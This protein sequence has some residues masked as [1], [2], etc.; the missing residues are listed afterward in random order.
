VG[1]VSVD[2]LENIGTDL[3]HTNNVS[4]IDPLSRRLALISS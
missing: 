4:Y 2:D 1:N 3:D